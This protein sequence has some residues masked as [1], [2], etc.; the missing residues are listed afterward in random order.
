M[1]IRFAIV[2]C[3]GA[4]VPVAAALA[5]STVASLGS[6][7][8]LDPRLAAE[9]GSIHGAACAPSLEALLADATIDA[10]YIAVPHDLLAPLTHQALTSG[11]HALVEKPLA[12]SLADVDALTALATQRRLALGVFYELRHAGQVAQARE[13]VAA[14][15][16]GR[17]IGLRIQTLIDKADS[18][19]RLGLSGR[20]ANPWRAQ[21]RRAGGGVVLMNSS[22]QLDAARAITGLDV[23]SVSA[24][25]ATLVADV[26]VEDLAAA[27]LRYSNGAL[28]SLFAGAHLAGD[29]GE[30]FAIFGTEGQIKVPSLYGDEPVQLYLR[31]DHDGFEAGRWLQLPAAPTQVY[32]SALDAFAHAARDGTPPPVGARD[33]R[34]V[35]A[36]VQAIYR[37]AAEQRTV[38]LDDAGDPV[39]RRGA[40]AAAA[41]A[42][43]AHSSAPGARR[44]RIS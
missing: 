15:A 24:H 37:S 9:L 36:V 32:S 17:V 22:H 40:A 8:D 38:R 44:R 18:Y 2:G 21:A 7:Y 31:R 33:A 43:R 23:V 35:L 19:W 29:G 4:A 26:E 41:R 25:T 20:S 1:T 34:H 11:K 16:I 12:L 5:A 30:Y 42:R 14:G 10:V 27:T 28:G 3:G 13:L 6:V 39:R